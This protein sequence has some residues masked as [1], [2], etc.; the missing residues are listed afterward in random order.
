MNDEK[1][2][3]N[4]RCRRRLRH[5]NVH[6]REEEHLLL[7]YIHHLFVQQRRKSNEEVERQVHTHTHNDRLESSQI[8]AICKGKKIYVD[9]LSNR[10]RS[11]MFA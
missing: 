3:S 6:N 8:L 1:K 5:S 4:F 11:N 7:T 10:M 9:G 2:K